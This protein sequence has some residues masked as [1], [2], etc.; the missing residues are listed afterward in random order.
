[1]KKKN[2][3][4]LGDCLTKLKEIRSASYDHCITDPPYNISNYS[5]KKEIGWYKSNP[6][7]KN[8]KKFTKIDESWDSFSN[9]DYYNFTIKWMKEIFR[10]VKPNGN[11]LIF[12]TYH[13][14][15]KI[16]YILS[17]FDKRII[18]SIIWYKRNAFPNI[19]LR[20]FCESTEQIIW[21]V[22]NSNKNAKNWIFNYDNMKK[23]TSNK[24][25]MRNMWDIP[26]TSV[27][28]KKYGKHPS[29]KPIELI[30]RI[31]KGCTEKN[32]SI[33]DPFSGSGT[34]SLVCAMNKRNYLGIEK[35][36]KYYKISLKR[37]KS[38]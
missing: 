22:N 19:T 15:Y 23:L 12:G 13:N 11:I 14:I 25:Q 10:I 4:I 3:I 27:K 2:K 35:N 32:Q 29:Q 33:I 24:K 36:K 34:V 6:T 28:E 31:I 30:D 9:D 17:K 16:G 38:L 37:L 8:K 7:W 26:M 20:M 21:S 5:G 18:N 1:M